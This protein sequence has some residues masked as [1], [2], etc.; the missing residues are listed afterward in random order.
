MDTTLQTWTLLPAIAGAVGLVIAAAFYFRVKALPEGN[1]TMQRIGG[2]I[3][4]GAMAFLAREYRVLAVYAV[5]VFGALS[6]L[7][8]VAAGGWFLAGA[9]LSLLAGFVGMKAATYG[10][11][12]TAQ[13]AAGGSK[14]NA[15]L[16]ALDGGAVMGL[17]VAGLSLLGLFVVYKLNVGGEALGTSLHAFAVGASSIALFA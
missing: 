15:L 4:A 11:V 13:A 14:P 7:I 5:V 8:S 1:E 6:A 2:Y 16:T 9:I 12:R 17:C 10:N 3:R